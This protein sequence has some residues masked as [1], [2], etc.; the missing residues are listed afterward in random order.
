VG[1]IADPPHFFISPLNRK[2]GQLTGLTAAG[3]AGVMAVLGVV[4]A[5][6]DVDLEADDPTTGNS[7]IAVIVPAQH[8]IDLLMA[9]DSVREREQARREVEAE[10]A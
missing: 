5:H 6:Y 4:A 3:P 1:A 7:G 10:R 9:E 8:I 2:L